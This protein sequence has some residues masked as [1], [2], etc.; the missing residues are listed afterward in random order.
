MWEDKNHNNIQDNN[1][2]GIGNIRVKLID[3]SGTQPAL[4]TTTNSNG[5]Y[6]FS[7]LNPGTYVLEF[8]KKDVSYNGVNI[9]NWMW[10]VQ[11]VNNNSK[12]LVDSDV[13]SDAT[14]KTNINQTK[15]FTLVSGQNDMTRDASITPIVIDLDGNG[16]QT[17][18]RADAA[19]SF[20]LFGNGKAVQSGWISGGEGFLAVDSNGNGQ[21]DD[22]SE[23]FGGT[24]KGAGFAQLAS[25][26]SNGDGL[27]DVADSAFADLLIWRDANGNHQSDAGELMTLAEAGVA[28]LDVRFSELPFLD[29]QGNLHLERSSA[30]MADGRSVDMTDVYFAVAADDAAA[31]GVDLPELAKL[32][33][34]GSLPGD[35]GALIDLSA[36]RDAGESSS[37]ADAGL[38]GLNV[39]VQGDASWD[40]N[41]ELHLEQST[42]AGGE[43]VDITDSCFGVAA[44]DDALMA[45]AP[46]ADA[47][48]LF[49]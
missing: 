42:T 24:A 19:G 48:W 18:S 7:N 33:Q 34:D 4:T 30:T 8:D 10:A 17:V 21:I 1:E 28:A 15:P 38:A 29:R 45:E 35:G 31:A 25:Y 40:A 46:V 44:N 49:A 14:A 23:L 13:A 3:T 16:I 32:L 12:D 41:A 11:D 6:L 9:K 27:V 36:W 2:P 5:N 43:V 20:D 37:L 47:G 22:I 26:D 39:V